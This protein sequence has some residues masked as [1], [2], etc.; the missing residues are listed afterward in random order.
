[1]IQEINDF[2]GK[3]ENKGE[4]IQITDDNVIVIHKEDKV[5]KSIT[6]EE[7]DKQISILETFKSFCLDIKNKDIID[8]K[9]ISPNKWLNSEWN[10]RIKVTD[11]QHRIISR[12]API[13]LVNLQIEPKNPIYEH[14]GYIIVYINSIEAEAYYLLE[15]LGIEIEYKNDFT[16]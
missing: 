16:D 14:I 4:F 9:I 11:A 5:L 6:Y 7:I 3:L 13:F 10:Y 12:E 8:N 1:M 2:C 15:Q